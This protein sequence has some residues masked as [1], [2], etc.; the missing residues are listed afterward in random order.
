[1]IAGSCNYHLETTSKTLAGSVFKGRG[2][3]RPACTPWA[4][5]PAAASNSLGTS[6]PEHRLLCR[7]H[8]LPVETTDVA[9]SFRMPRRQSRRRA[10]SI[11]NGASCGNC[12]TRCQIREGTMLRP[13]SRRPA[14]WLVTLRMEHART[15]SCPAKNINTSRLFVVRPTARRSISRGGV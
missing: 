2:G 10:R 1:M 4:D 14:P 11:G 5:H 7:R 3:G 9:Y 12:R 6:D 8:C 15:P 13:F